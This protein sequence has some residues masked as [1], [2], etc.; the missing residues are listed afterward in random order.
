MNIY[1]IVTQYYQNFEGEKRIIGRSILNRAIYAFFVGSHTGKLCLC[2]YAMHA[3][4]WVTALLALEH[5]QRGVSQG[6]VWIVPLVNPDGAL[7]CQEGLKSISSRSREAMLLRLSED[8]SQWKANANAV[9][10]NV[11]FAARWG[12]GGKNIVCPSSANFIGVRPF[13]EAES[14]ALKNFTYRVQ[15]NAT[16]SWHSK[17]EEI[18][19]QFHQ[20]PFRRLRDYRLAR[21]L[22]NATGY[23]IRNCKNSAGGYKDWCV[24]TLKIPAFTIEVGKEEWTHPFDERVLGEI[25]TCCG[26]VVERFMKKL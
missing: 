22:Q 24:E 20:P 13:S 8:F 23:Q 26:D 9:D 14:L 5:V 25:V 11:N 17:G 19:Y 10:L 6:G 4:E 2:Q 7:L 18:Y 12:T 16:I 21:V 3:R 15:P 1:E